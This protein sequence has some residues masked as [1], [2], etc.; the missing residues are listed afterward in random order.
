MRI[1]FRALYN[2]LAITAITL[3][4]AF[5]SL[6]AAA[7]DN[8]D[9]AIIEKK[10]NIVVESMQH[11]EAEPII[12]MLP[13]KI[14]AEF[15]KKAKVSVSRIKEL[16]IMVSEKS[17]NDVFSQ[18]AKLEY[19]TDLNAAK[20]LQS[21]I[22]R[23]YL[24]IPYQFKIIGQDLG[25]VNTGTVLALKDEGLWYLMRLESPQHLAIVSSVYPDLNDL[26]IFESTLDII[27]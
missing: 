16:L 12:D 27:E 8:Q 9:R 14:L 24:I 2:N 15:A 19:S 11:Q 7:Y 26:E 3:G 13:P 20:V 23:D 17:V 6:S 5:S 4:L 25:M 1:I 18:G 21:K 22:G 10:L